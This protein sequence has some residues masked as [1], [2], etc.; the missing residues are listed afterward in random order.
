MPPRSRLAAL[1]V[2]AASLVL[3][4]RAAAVTSSNW[5]GYVAHAPHAKFRTVRGAWTVPAVDCSIPRKTYSAAWIGLGG[6]HSSSAA[7]EQTGTEADCRHGIPHYG[8]WY[9]LVPDAE[10]LLP[11]AV[12]PGDKMAARVSVDGGR[13]IVRIRNLT[14]GAVYRK[15]LTAPAIDTTSAEW[16]VEA[17]SQCDGLLGPCRVLPLANFGAMKFT[18]ARAVTASGHQGVIGDPAWAA[19]PIDLRATTLTIGD[20]E[21][22]GDGTAG[23]TPGGLSASGASFTVSYAPAA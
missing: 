20:A 7:L 9:E 11:M 3:P 22:T 1:S 14:R 5:S 23:A 13:A 15:T 6:Y 10:V 4:A 16:I 19:S 8:A 17:P 12:Q 21:D 18:A 2:L